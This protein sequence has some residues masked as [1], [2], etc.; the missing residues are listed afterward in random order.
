MKDEAVNGQRIRCYDNGG[1]T[2]DRYTVAYMDSP[3]HGNLID[4]V[5]MSEHPFHP[6]G[7]GQHTHGHPG[8]HLGK[9][10]RL[11]D[12]PEDCRKLVEQDTK[13]DA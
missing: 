5:A 11:A 6:Q 7:F 4:M 3:S 9:R 1:R 2:M 10:I 8:A 12:L 13:G